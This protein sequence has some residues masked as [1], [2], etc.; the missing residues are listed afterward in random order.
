MNKEGA[1]AAAPFSKRDTNGGG[2]KM[3][4]KNL[5]KFITHNL[6]F[7]ATFIQFPWLHISI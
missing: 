7:P 4:K 3:K 1:A 6:A 5:P 2:V